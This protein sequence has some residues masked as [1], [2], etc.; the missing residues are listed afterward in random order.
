MPWT[1]IS[2]RCT[3]GCLIWTASRFPRM[4][5]RAEPGWIPLGAANPVWDLARR[6]RGDTDPAHLA[7]AEMRPGCGTWK[8][9]R[10]PST[11]GS[12]RPEYWTKW[13]TRDPVIQNA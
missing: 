1:R 10:Y 7:R 5:R 4:R 8:H 12:Y 6:W 13:F 11:G 2:H 9:L 3:N